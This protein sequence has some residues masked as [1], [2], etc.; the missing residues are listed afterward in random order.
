MPLPGRSVKNPI[1]QTLNL[2]R[3]SYTQFEDHNEHQQREIL[4][5]EQLLMSYFGFWIKYS[6]RTQSL[7]KTM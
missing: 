1:R 3:T 4:G 5:Q 6:V 7:S 2:R